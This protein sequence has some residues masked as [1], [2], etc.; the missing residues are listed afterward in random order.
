MKKN[1]IIMSIILSA[2]L[3]IFSCD[4]KY[5]VKEG[6]IVDKFE[7]TIPNK[8]LMF[9]IDNDGD[10]SIIENTLIVNQYIL[11]KYPIVNQLEKGAQ[12]KYKDPSFGKY[13]RIYAN[14]ILEV[15]GENQK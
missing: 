3:T 1:K 7:L 11:S 10:E 9:L 6:K 13:E 14:Y 5:E 4:N 15:Y 2:L 12:L 8:K